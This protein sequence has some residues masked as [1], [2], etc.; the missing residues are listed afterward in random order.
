MRPSTQLAS[1]HLRIPRGA[2][3][4]IGHAVE[5]RVLLHAPLLAPPHK[6]AVRVKVAIVLLVLHIE[7]RDANTRVVI[8]L[9]KRW[10]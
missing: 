6:V 10:Q 7:C 8:I 2:Y 3:L 1:A 5:P 4:V 9:Q